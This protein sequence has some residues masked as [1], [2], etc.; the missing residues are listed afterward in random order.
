MQWEKHNQQKV[1]VSNNIFKFQIV[2]RKN[3]EGSYIY[4]QG[5]P[6]AVCTVKQLLQSLP[7][8]KRGSIAPGEETM[9]GLM[10]FNHQ[11]R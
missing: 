7:E 1:S 6:F 11:R 2:W 3:I 9:E 10:C 8:K 5:P 4:R